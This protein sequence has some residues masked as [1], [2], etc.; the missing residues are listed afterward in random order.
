M[1]C[2]NFFYFDRMVY[3]QQNV[4]LFCQVSHLIVAL[5]QHFCKGLLKLCKTIGLSSK[6][7]RMIIQMFLCTV[8]CIKKMSSNM[9]ILGLLKIIVCGFLEKVC[10]LL[11]RQS[12]SD[13][14]THVCVCVGGVFQRNNC[15][16][17]R[18]AAPQDL[19]TSLH[20]C[21]KTLD[22]RCLLWKNPLNLPN[23]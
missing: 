20:V 3:T 23:E 17:K 9:V 2:C 21:S 13:K 8:H 22:I 14:P 6:M 19:K 5:P 4:A 18:R 10:F 1:N 11:C 7:S 15:L 12:E 16:V